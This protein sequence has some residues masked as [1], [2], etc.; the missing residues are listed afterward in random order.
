MCAVA[1]V[2]TRPEA[3]LAGTRR[4][5]LVLGVKLGVYWL[6]VTRA[7][8]LAWHGVYRVFPSRGGLKSNRSGVGR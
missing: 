6:S 1:A 7:G 2:R 3:E 4:L 8:E 5:T